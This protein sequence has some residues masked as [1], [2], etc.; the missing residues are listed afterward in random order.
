MPVVG[1]WAAAAGV[2]AAVGAAGVLAA[3]AALDGKRRFFYIWRAMSGGVDRQLADVKA[4]LLGAPHVRGVVLDVGAGLGTTLH[5]LSPAV[6]RVVAVEP[7]AH[8]HAGL[9]A[10]GAAAGFTGDGRLT[11]LGAS[12]DALPLPDASVDTVVAVLVLC[13]VPHPAAAVA[14]LH[15][16]LKPGGALVFLEHVAP[17]RGTGSSSSSGSGGDPAARHDD[18]A[19]AALEARLLMAGGL[20]PWLGDGCHLDRTTDATIRAQPGWASVETHTTI[21]PYGPLTAAAR[22]HVH[23]VAIKA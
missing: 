2:A 18:G 7:N 14:E 23:G 16:V 20:W 22:R 11:V 21:M 3:V 6:E 17:Q 8:M 13:S 9:R 5:Y 4:G 19:W 15:R 1:G 10:A 12:A